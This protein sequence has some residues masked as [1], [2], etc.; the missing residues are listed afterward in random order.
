MKPLH[1]A[2]YS[3]AALLGF[4]TSTPQGKPHAPLE[5]VTAF[6][7]IVCVFIAACVLSLFNKS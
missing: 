1:M 7:V 3:A 2:L 5:C 6:A 4:M